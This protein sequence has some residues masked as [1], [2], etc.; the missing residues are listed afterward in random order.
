MGGPCTSPK[1]WGHFGVT[2][3]ILGSFWGH[4]GV[5][6]G[7]ILGSFWGHFGITFVVI[8]GSF[9]GHFDRFLL[10]IVTKM[11]DWRVVGKDSASCHNV[12]VAFLPWNTILSC[13]HQLFHYP[14]E[15]VFSQK[16]HG[17]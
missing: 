10:C 9:W 11:N 13:L 15:K 14:D 6:L 2:G 4:F 12:F 8:L 3:V 17:F 1:F 5:T 7:V 16:P